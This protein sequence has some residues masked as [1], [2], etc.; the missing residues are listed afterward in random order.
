M[1]MFFYYFVGFWVVLVAFGT[2]MSNY[3]LWQHISEVR[4]KLEEMFAGKS[5]DDL[6]QF[7]HGGCEVQTSEADVENV[8][9]EG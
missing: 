2:A 5:S 8:D 7:V 3:Y 9:N 1:E 4:K 6:Y